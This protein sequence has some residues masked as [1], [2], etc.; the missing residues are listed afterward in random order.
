MGF[1]LLL[2]AVA[3]LINYAIAA[4]GTRIIPPYVST[5]NIRGLGPPS[6]S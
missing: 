5:S 4:V 1:Q 3:D 2:R 6:M